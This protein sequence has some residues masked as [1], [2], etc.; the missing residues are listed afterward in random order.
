[1]G[2]HS[3]LEVHI[4][5]YQTTVKGVGIPGDDRFIYCFLGL[6]YGKSPAWPKGSWD[7]YPP[8]RGVL[9][10]GGF[11]V[12]RSGNVRCRYGSGMLPGWHI[13]QVCVSGR[14]RAAVSWERWLLLRVLRARRSL[15]L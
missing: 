15:P 12:C 6:I 1:M 14:S 9:P 2:G 11:P 7:T 3:M 10:C 4:V 5:G 13:F 8:G